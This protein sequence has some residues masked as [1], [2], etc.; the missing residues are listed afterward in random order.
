MPIYE[1]VCGKCG[2][3]FESLVRMGG[4]KGVCC[5]ECGA[6]E[7]RKRVSAFGIGGGA[8]RVKTAS[9]SCGT[10]SSHSCSTCH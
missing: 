2:C 4:E 7:V 8:N 9:S 10:C 3:R 6:S 5:P 1:F